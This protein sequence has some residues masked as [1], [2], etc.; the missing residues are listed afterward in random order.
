M[1][2]QSLSSA[3]KLRRTPVTD[4]H[5]FQIKLLGKNRITT[6]VQITSVRIKTF[7]KEVICQTPDT[8]K[9]LVYSDVG[10]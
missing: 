2:G 10:F 7:I 1:R 4:F 9:K 6:R 3:Y 5:Q 8:L